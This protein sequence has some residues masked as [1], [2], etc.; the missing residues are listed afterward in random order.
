MKVRPTAHAAAVLV[1]SGRNDDALLGRAETAPN[2]GSLLKLKKIL[3]PVDF[4]ECSKKALT[5]AIPYA[6]QFG[7]QLIIL[8]VI[9]PYYAVDPYGLSQIERVEA[10]LEQEGKKQLTALVQQ[11]IPSQIDGEIV[12]RHGQAAPEIV[13][14]AKELNADLIVISTH[15]RTGLK[16][17]MF[18][19]TAESVVRQAPCP[20]LTV[21]ETEH[22]FI[23]N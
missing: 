7:A 10:E 12:L 11:N 23:G 9:A 8:H 6:K 19:S 20:V 16:H 13:V 22:E 18:G 4:S 17:V 3:V 1:E 21:R 2:I 15:G 14:A 5:Y